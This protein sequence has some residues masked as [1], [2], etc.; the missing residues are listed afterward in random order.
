MT[1]PRRPHFHYYRD[2][3][4]DWYWTEGNDVDGPMCLDDVTSQMRNAALYHRR[5]LK[6]GLYPMEISIMHY[7]P[8]EPEDLP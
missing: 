8:L 3:L 4:G 2:L 1:E 7:Y 5:T 6:N